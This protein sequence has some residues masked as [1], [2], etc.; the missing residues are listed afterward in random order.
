MRHNQLLNADSFDPISQFQNAMRAGPPWDS[1][2]DFA[3]HRSFCGMDLYPRQLTL[4]KLIYLETDQMTW[5]DE[6]TINSWAESFKDP[7]NPMGIQPDIWDRVKYLR[8]NGYHHFPHIQMVMGRRASKG[9]IGGIIG[10]E[11]LA[12]F[13]SLDDWQRHF[14]IVPNAVGELTVV[15]TTQGQ[16]AK[17]QFA[18][19]RRTVEACAYLQPHIVGS[20]Y[21]EFSVRTPA[22]ERHIAEM[23][24]MGTPMD[25]EFASL[26]CVASAAVSTGQRGGSGF[27][28]AYDEFAHVITG[29]GSSKTDT[30]LY[31]AFQPSLDQF[32]IHKMT[33]IPSSPYS[34]IGQFYKL[35]QEGCVTLEDYNKREGK[36]VRQSFSQ[37][38]RGTEVEEVEDDELEVQ[39]ADPEMLIVQ[40]PSWESYRDWDRGDIPMRPG[41]TRTIKRWKR[42]V[43]YDIVGDAPENKAMARMREK[44]PEKF[45][46][47]RGAQFASVEDAYLNEAMVDKIFDRP[48]WRDDDLVPQERGKFSIAYR[49][50]ADPSRTNANFGFA[51]GHI[52]DAPC[53]ACGWDPNHLPPGTPSKM[54]Y[55]HKCKAPQPGH[56]MPHVIIDRL[57]VWK[58]ADFPQHTIN[59]LTVGRDLGDFLR[60]WPSMQVMS[61]DHYA[62]AF[63]LI[64]QQKVDFPHIRIATKQFTRA[65]NDKRFERFKAAVNLGLIHSY[66][67]NFFDDGM[68]LLE[69]ELKFL[70]VKN[71][72]VDCQEVGPVTTKDLTD[73]V[74][75][76][77]V[78]LLEEHLERWYKGRN[79]AVFG[80]TYAAGLQ[81]GSEQQRQA[82][83]GIGGREAPQDARAVR[84]AANRKNLAQMRDMRDYADPA[85]GL[86]AGQR[87]FARARVGRSDRF[88]GG[89]G[90]VRGDRSRGRG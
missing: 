13:Y 50:H 38:F 58:P 41:R 9:I 44:N 12:Y 25:R 55:N 34:K 33:Y 36:F 45:K 32:G 76:V 35:Y 29:T 17:R 74:M 85:R 18:D 59:Y 77:T 73:A 47:E 54:R 40:L 42:P 51:I 43:Q 1:I 21:T 27:M 89:R 19:I 60:K 83:M 86:N 20:K 78:E 2:V 6:D 22:D 39:V 46:V 7:V 5:Y 62:A 37:Q 16:A 4:L 48:W 68:C 79:R 69:Q 66:K 75:E 49:G 82:I 71:G 70:Q 88:G 24:A 53:D 90:A 61:Y 28:N 14:G 84:A 56:V 8:E 57:H 3:V 81:S 15:A 30:E 26:Y 63:G 72:K 52:E 10:A 67:D 87:Q 80:S 65:E 23:A 64:D 31:N 11:R